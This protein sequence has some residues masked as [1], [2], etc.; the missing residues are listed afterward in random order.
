MSDDLERRRLRA[1]LGGLAAGAKL[2]PE[3]RADRARTAG[4]A[5]GEA[6]R[7]VREE[8]GLPPLEPKGKRALPSADELAPYLE[9]IDAEQHD[10]PLGYDARYREAVLRLRRDVADQALA[11]FNAKGDK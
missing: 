3:Q 9:A 10:P 8:A 7:R 6:R 2:T 11:H 5:S 1:S 4:K